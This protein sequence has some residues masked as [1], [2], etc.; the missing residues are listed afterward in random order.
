M[1]K[2]HDAC[3]VIHRILSV[4]ECVCVCLLA[5]VLVCVGSSLASAQHR[6][7]ISL[8]ETRLTALQRAH[9]AEYKQEVRRACGEDAVAQLPVYVPVAETETQKQ[10]RK[11]K[12][13]DVQSVPASEAREIY[14]PEPEVERAMKK[15]L[16]ELKAKAK[17]M[18]GE[19]MCR[20]SLNVRIFRPRRNQFY[21]IQLPEAYVKCGEA[22][23][24]GSCEGGSTSP[25][26]LA[27][28]GRG[29]PSE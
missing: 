12:L 25:R 2:A 4:K 20:N 23:A 17:L 7:E 11:R 6:Q 3:L 21:E 10:D 28:L 22:Q 19:E 24:K 8:C 14:E 1:T 15:R 5:S 18:A 29:E 26:S 13:R 16:K 27:A 9:E